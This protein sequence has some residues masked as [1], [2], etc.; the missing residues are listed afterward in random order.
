MGLT[1]V[2]LSGTLRVHIIK[3]D[4]LLK[5]DWI[6]KGDPYV[7]LFLDDQPE[8]KGKTTVKKGTSVI[9]KEFFEVPVEGKYEWLTLRCMD[10]DTFSADDF[11]GEVRVSLKDVWKKGQVKGP[12]ELQKR[13]R[14]KGEAA[15]KE[16]NL[17][18]GKLDYIV[19]YRPFSLDGHLTIHLERGEEIV[20]KDWTGSKADPYV[21][22]LADEEEIGKG[23]VS[24][25]CENPVWNT[26]L[27][28]DVAGVYEKLYLSVWDKDKGKDDYISHVSIPV[29]D[30]ITKKDISGTFPL[31][32]VQDD[33]PP[34]PL[35]KITAS[36]KWSPPILQGTIVLRGLRASDLYQSDWLGNKNDPFV[37]VLLDGISMGKTNV[38]KNQSNA[39]W[40]EEIRFSCEGVHSE[41]LIVVWDKDRLK[42]DALGCLQ[43]PIPEIVKKKSLAGEFVLGPYLGTT[44]GGSLAFQLQF[45]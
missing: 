33:K 16:D 10:K 36:I 6:G 7:Q 3:A 32:R 30:V 37:E 12:S 40:S 1:E 8:P 41:F 9:F 31:E 22:I 2:T 25:N 11:L 19:E 5:K 38:V 4:D 35:G 17:V 23:P 24:K 21:I 15:Q 43:V 45:N 14:P 27:E 39:E 20:H 26:T 42:N 29:K 13:H 34:Q 18:A 28:I 44:G